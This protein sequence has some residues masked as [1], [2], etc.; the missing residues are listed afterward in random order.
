MRMNPSALPSVRPPRRRAFPQPLPIAPITGPL[1]PIEGRR[2]LVLADIENLSYGARDRALKVSYRRLAQVLRAAA[3][4]C[5]LHAFFSRRPREEQ[6]CRY[7]E[8]RGWIAHPRDIETVSTY[9]G[10]RVRGNSDNHI[11]FA[12]GLLVSRSSS[13]TVAIASGDGDLVSDLAR[14]VAGLPKPREVVTLSLA[15]STSSRLN[16]ASNPCI[17]ANIEL[18]LDCLRSI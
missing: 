1:R 8:E 5:S 3:R 17:A 4:A 2:V 10:L 16:A 11:L 9:L 14:A 7:F 6:R 12:T 15:G 18:G 13:D